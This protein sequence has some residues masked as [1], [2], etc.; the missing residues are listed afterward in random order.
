[1]FEE[2]RDMTNQ[3]LDTA[4]EGVVK[5]ICSELNHQ[6]GVTFRQIEAYMKIKLDLELASFKKEWATQE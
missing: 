6:D 1:M 5:A 3:H 4:F 2:L